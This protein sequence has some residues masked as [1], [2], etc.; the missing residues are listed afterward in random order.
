MEE[1]AIREGWLAERCTRCRSSRGS[2]RDAL[3]APCSGPPPARNPGANWSRFG[4]VPSFCGIQACVLTPRRRATILARIMRRMCRVLA[5][6]CV[7]LLAISCGGSSGAAVDSG[8]NHAG[9]GGGQSGG[10]SG[11]TGGSGSSVADTHPVDAGAFCLAENRALCSLAFQCVPSASRDSS[12][13]ST[14]GSSLSECQNTIVPS[15]CTTAATDC[16]VYD[17]ALAS[18]CMT[19]LISYSCADLVD[20]AEPAECTLA[21]SSSTGTGGTIGTGG[22]PGS[23]SGGGS[24]ARLDWADSQARVA[25]PARAVGLARAASLA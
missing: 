24:E 22:R 10:G 6:G 1:L 8:G 5:I 17:A 16:P 20:L 3:P 4:L 21:C 11:G 7:S 12:F 23:G 2:L 15:M 9:G 25:Y 19:T 18:I 14:F 13:I